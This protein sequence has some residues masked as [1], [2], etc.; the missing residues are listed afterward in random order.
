MYYRPTDSSE[1]YGANAYR[2]NIPMS[3]TRVAQ[4]PQCLEMSVKRENLADS[5]FFH[6]N[7]TRAIG[8]GKFL[9]GIP[10]ENI[11]RLPNNI[12]VHPQRCYQTPVFRLPKKVAKLTGQGVASVVPYAGYGLVKNVIESKQGDTLQK[13]VRIVR[14]F[15]SRLCIAFPNMGFPSI[16][17]QSGHCRCSPLRHFLTQ[18]LSYVL[19]PHWLEV[20]GYSR[21]KSKEHPPRGNFGRHV[22]GQPMARGNVYSLS[23][24]HLARIA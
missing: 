5:M 7:E 22:N 13:Q 2:D 3:M 21:C 8:E 23:N 19:N 16:F 11:P 9:V 12:F 17:R 6:Q 20:V 4:E 24:G 15:V 10:S 1:S 18:K 14:Q